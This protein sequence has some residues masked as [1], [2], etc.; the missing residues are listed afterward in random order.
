M[1]NN[2]NFALNNFFYS[3]LKNNRNK[4]QKLTKHFDVD[5]SDDETPTGF[6]DNVIKGTRFAGLLL[7]YKKFLL[8]MIK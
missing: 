7:K 2:Q 4:S 6:E 5:G 3:G 1:E 8:D